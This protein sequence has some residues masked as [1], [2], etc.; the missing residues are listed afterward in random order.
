MLGTRGMIGQDPSEAYNI[1]RTCLHKFVPGVQLIHLHFFDGNKLLINRWLQFFPFT[2]FSFARVVDNFREGQREVLQ[3]LGCA[4]F[5]LSTDSPIFQA[6][7][8]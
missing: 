2:Y 5:L 8:R 7:M 3:T 1:L 6:W 4:R